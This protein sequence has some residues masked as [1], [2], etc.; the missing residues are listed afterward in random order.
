MKDRLR[1]VFALMLVAVGA[2]VFAVGFRASLA[3]VYHTFYGAD[4]VV[5]GITRLPLWLRFLVPVAGATMAGA[6]AH[7]RRA[8]AQNVSNVMEAIAL[9]HVQ[10]S[11]RA[12]MSRVASSWT[13]I[14]GGMSIGREG[15]LIELGGALG[16]A[17]GRATEVSLNQTRVLVAAGTAAGFAAAYSTPFAAVLFVLETI[18]GVAAPE[19]LLP[20]M[21]GTVAATLITRTTLGPGPIYGQRAF[22]LESGVDLFS[23]AALGVL[24][25]I[26]AIVFKQVLA[27]FEDRFERHPVPQPWRA[28]IGGGLVG[29][30]GRRSRETAT[31]R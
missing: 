23:A 24:G 12:T 18:A 28:M 17:V 4:D 26:A 25:A 16:A 11:L 8:P 22:A 1:F 7:F 30:I 27:T 13:A 15:P 29:V 19:L 20:V 10:L 2:A 6:I 9:G 14:A 31:S 21:A 3:F 5:D